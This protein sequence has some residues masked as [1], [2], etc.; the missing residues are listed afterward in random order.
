MKMSKRAVTA[1]K[2]TYG[3]RGMSLPALCRL[4]QFAAQNSGIDPRNYFDPEDRRAGRAQV[5]RDG[6]SAYR[7]EARDIGT[8][9]RR[10]KA[11]LAVAG[12]EGVG[13]AEIIEAGPRA[14]SGRLTWEP[15]GNKGE[16]EQGFIW[17]YTPGQYFPTEY[18]KAAATVL[19]AAIRAVR[20]ARPAQRQAVTTIAGLRALNEKNGGCWFEPSAMRFFGTR[21]ES[22]I[23][24]GRYFVTSEQPPHG[25]R[26]YS[27]RSFDDEGDVSTVGKFCSYPSRAAAVASIP[28]E[29]TEAA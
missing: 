23:I 29:Q 10:F 16:P 18:R 15:L 12:A 24:R 22:G 21:I 9:W 1:I 11:A 25:T 4:V 6:V 19:E 13:D 17:S 2:N 7:T 8:D 27:L 26:A 5:Y 14:Y 28:K 20:Q 3:E